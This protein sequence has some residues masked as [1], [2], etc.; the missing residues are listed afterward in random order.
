LVV[1]LMALSTIIFGEPV[2]VSFTRSFM[3]CADPTLVPPNFKTGNIFIF[4]FN[5][6]L[7]RIILE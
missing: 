2:T 4:A 6:R 1:P 3:R 7:K 5:V